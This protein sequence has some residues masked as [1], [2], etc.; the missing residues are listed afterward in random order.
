MVVAPLPAKRSGLRPALQDEIVALLEPL[1]VVDRI[2]VGP[3]GLDADAAHEAR[4]HAAARDQIRHGDLL[5]HPDGVVLDG[6][7]VAE[8]EELRPSGRAGE[9]G[10]GH[11]GAHV[12]ARGRGVMLVDHQ[13]FEARLI[14]ELV[15]GE[16]ALVIGR[17]LLAVEEAVRQLEPERGI[18]VALRVRELVMWHL[19]EVVELHARAVSG[20]SGCGAERKS[21]TRRA[22]VSGCSS[23]GRWPHASSTVS[24]ARGRARWYCSPQTTGTMRSS[25]PHTISVGFVTRGRKR[26]RRGSCMYGF[27]VSRAVISRLRVAIST[28]AGVGGRPNNSSHSGTV[29]G[30]C[31]VMPRSCGGG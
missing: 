29:V 20:T 19:A 22:N 30:S 11:V 23:G 15:L 6:Q 7:D 5:G 2:R 25:R 10:S 31:T 17:G 13:A 14:G 24:V 28:S 4:E 3:P 18:L 16:V 12:H 27:Q 8:Q 1:A 9:N 26:S 21:S